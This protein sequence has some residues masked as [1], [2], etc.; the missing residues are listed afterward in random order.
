MRKLILRCGLPPGDI[1]L[2]TAA[3]R[4]LHQCYPGRFLTDV[5][6]LSPQLWETNPNITL[7]SEDDPEV[8]QIECSYPLINHSNRTALHC[9]HGFIQFLNTRLRLAMR[10]TRIKGDIHLSE[11]EKSWCSQ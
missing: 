9:L 8:E 11:L 1:V 6:T 7:L 2:L 3:V 5:R 4:D 10:L